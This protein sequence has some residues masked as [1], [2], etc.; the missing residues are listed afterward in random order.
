[1]DRPTQAIRINDPGKE[2]TPKHAAIYAR[3]AASQGEEEN[4]PLASLLA[5]ATLV[6][7]CRAYC[8]EHG[9]I[10]DKKQIY[11]EVYNGRTDY[12][13]RPRL[14]NVL[15]KAAAPEP[16]QREFDIVV[17]ASIGQLSPDQAQAAAILDELERHHI[18][19][20]CVDDVHKLIPTVTEQH[21]CCNQKEDV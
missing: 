7:E 21:T 2:A 4:I 16:E 19:V 18:T 5:L 10:I 15:H 8:Q 17:I 12:I 3:T 6:E 1:M 9:Y 20:E 13:K 11:R 14:A